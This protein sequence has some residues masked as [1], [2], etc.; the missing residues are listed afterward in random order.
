MQKK[1]N[2]AHSGKR[3]PNSQIRVL[4]LGLPLKASITKKIPDSFEVEFGELQNGTVALVY[5]YPVDTP[6]LLHHRCN[7]ANRRL[8]LIVI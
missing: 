3:K 7:V 2:A 1:L 6:T 4:S 8:S 5:S